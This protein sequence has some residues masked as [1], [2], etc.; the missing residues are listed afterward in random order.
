MLGGGVVFVCLLCN[1]CHRPP[2]DF[3][4]VVHGA[5]LVYMIATALFFVLIVL[6]FH[7]RFSVRCNSQPLQGATMA[8]AP[9]VQQAEEGPMCKICWAELNPISGFMRAQRACARGVG[10]TCHEVAMNAL[11]VQS[12]EIATARSCE[13]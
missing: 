5:P 3:G 7:R 8:E 2:T 6:S 1:C 9:A 4:T 13:P 12:I 10:A 11:S